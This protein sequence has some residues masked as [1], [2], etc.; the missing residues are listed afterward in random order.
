MSAKGVLGIIV[1][2]FVL[3]IVIYLA[4]PNPGKKALQREQTAMEDVT[5][6]RI[7]TQ[8]SKNSRPVIGRTYAAQCPNKEHVLEQNE[9]DFS[10]Y[11]RVG[12]QEF[13]RKNSYQWIKGAPG[14]DLFVALPTPRPCLSNPGEPSSRPPGGA[15]A[16]RLALEADIKDGSIEKGEKREYK[17]SPCQEWSVT[18]FS[19]DRLGSYVTCLRESDSLPLYTRNPATDDFRMYYEWGTSVTVDAPDLDSP[20]QKPALP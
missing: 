9:G 15:E 19:G 1:G 4:V 12:D 3:I 14:P 6:W 11:I 10:E 16:M 2:V 7:V 13:Y 8:V 18:R 17:G 5:S 20:G